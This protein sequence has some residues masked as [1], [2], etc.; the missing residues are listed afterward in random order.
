MTYNFILFILFLSFSLLLL[1]QKLESFLSAQPTIL[2]EPEVSPVFFKTCMTT[3][4]VPVAG[5]GE[6]VQAC[7]LVYMFAQLYLGFQLGTFPE[8]KYLH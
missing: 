3:P 2:L 1:Y 5:G 7:L 8:S 4:I 6:S